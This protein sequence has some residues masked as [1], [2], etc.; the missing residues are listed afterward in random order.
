M[1]LAHPKGALRGLGGASRGLGRRP[2]GL[3]GALRGLGR[4]PSPLGGALRALGAPCGAC[5]TPIWA[6]SGELVALRGIASD[7]DQMRLAH[8]KGALRGLGGASRGLGGASGPWRR[9]SGPFPAPF[10]PWRRPSGPGAPCGACVTPIWARSGELVALRRKI[11]IRPRPNAP[12][13]PKSRRSGPWRPSNE[14][15]PYDKAALDKA[16][17]RQG[18]PSGHGGPPMRPPLATRPPARLP[19]APAG[20]LPP[21][22]LQACSGRRNCAPTDLFSLHSYQSPPQPESAWSRFP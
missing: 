15:A 7:H 12:S 21:P 8:P 19:A 17:L 20:R 11:C 5:V 3:G 1:R 14:A 18:R 4:R 2:S 13:A 10:A 9:Q 6:R 16:A 22:A